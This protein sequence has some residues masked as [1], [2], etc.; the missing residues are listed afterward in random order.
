MV[1][2]FYTKRGVQDYPTVKS[3]CIN[4]SRA[5]L[6]R[7]T[8]D[9]YGISHVVSQRFTRLQ[10]YKPEMISTTFHLSKADFHL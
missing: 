6:S 3:R 5:T 8:A 9:R 4:L 7:H 2:I 1:I 10:L